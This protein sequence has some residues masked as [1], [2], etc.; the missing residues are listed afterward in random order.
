MKSNFFRIN[1]QS[2][3]GVYWKE[4]KML[5][6]RRKLIISHWFTGIVATT[7]YIIIALFSVLAILYGVCW[8]NVY[9][10]QR[11]NLPQITPRKDFEDGL[12]WTIFELAGISSVAMVLMLCW[13]CFDTDRKELERKLRAFDQ[14]KLE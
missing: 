10:V 6:E 9:F 1:S 2:K 8:I 4:K 13:C 14:K 11:G 12:L 7:V 5:S 3:S